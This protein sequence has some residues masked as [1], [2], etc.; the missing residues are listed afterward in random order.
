MKKS[1]ISL[2]E[3]EFYDKTSSY[4]SVNDRNLLDSKQVEG[5]LIDLGDDL[6][7]ILIEEF[8]CNSY[9]NYFRSKGNVYDN[10]T[11]EI[12]SY[13]DVSS[14]KVCRYLINSINMISVMVGG[15]TYNWSLTDDDFKTTDI[16]ELR[17]RF[18]EVSSVTL[19]DF[20]ESKPAST[21]LLDCLPRLLANYLHYL[22]NKRA[23]INCYEKLAKLNPRFKVE[24]MEENLKTE[25][26]LIKDVLSNLGK[27]F[28]DREMFF[29]GSFMKGCY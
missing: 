18:D 13:V 14:E 29:T 2:I 1:L 28:I 24:M 11:Y 6:K 27:A 10:P 3:K 16:E 19:K 23:T 25:S 9:S 17:N 20:E 8:T 12:D 22:E 26:K 5:L 7:K 15:E 4:L 21:Y